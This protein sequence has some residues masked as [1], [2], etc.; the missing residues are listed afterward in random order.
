MVSVLSISR[1]AILIRAGGCRADGSRFAN[2]LTEIASHGFMV[3][4]SGPLLMP[5]GTTEGRDG[6]TLMSLRHNQTKAYWLTESINWAVAGAAGGK[7]GTV[8]TVKIAV[9]GQSCGGIEAYS[10]AYKDERIKH[11]GI[12]NS[13]VGGNPLLA[14]IKQPVGLFIG[15]PDDVAYTNVSHRSDLYL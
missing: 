10:A 2:F 15:G 5:F 9:A 14:Q 12:F 8:D 4:A 7:F 3:V 1:I 13:G 6:A 11:I